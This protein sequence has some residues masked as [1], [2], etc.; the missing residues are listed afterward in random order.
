ML[1]GVPKKRRRKFTRKHRKRV[2]ISMCR[3]CMAT[4]SLF[5][6]QTKFNALNSGTLGR[7]RVLLLFINEEQKD[8]GS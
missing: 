8:A 2:N 7:S 4:L 3:L 5:M 6:Q 1:G